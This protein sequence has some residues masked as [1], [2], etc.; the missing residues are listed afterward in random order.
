MI[1]QF[2]VG[3]SI[4]VGIHEFG[5]LIAAKGFGMRVEKFSIGFPPKIF[6]VKYGETEYSFGAVPLGGFVKI[7]GMIDES[8]DTKKMAQ[9]PEPYEF[10]AKPAWQ[11]LI[12]MLGGIIM[13]VLTGIIVFVSIT[14]FVGDNYI[15]I[16]EANK[17][18]I[19]AYE[20]GEKV[21]LQTGDRILTVNGEKV[22]RFKDL[23]SP[24]V[25]LGTDA[26]YT[27]DRNGQELRIDL[28]NDFIEDY[29][30][31]TAAGF[32]TV[33]RPF[34]IDEVQKDSPAEAAGL[35]PDDKILSINGMVTTYYAEFAAAREKFAGKEAVFL[36]ERNGQTMRKVIK[37]G[38]DNRVGFRP[39]S[40]LES[41]T[42]TYT[43]GESLGVGTAR[44]FSVV[45]N[46]IKAFG[47]I[48]AGEV[49]AQ[50]SI[51]GPIG[52]VKFFGG[53]W[54]WVHFWSLVGLLSMILAFM[55]LLP[56]PALDGGHVV[57]LLY[58]MV[59]GRKPS[60]KFLENAQKAGMLILLSI[61][62]FAIFNDVVNLF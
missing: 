52:I 42:T 48:F 49:S 34:A 37:I 1:G 26:Y 11:R 46:N 13:N 29:S 2:V 60:D 16:D 59:S 10:R 20:L 22:E 4:L 32:I 45:T 50:K 19:N 44:A 3:L 55:N 14:Y 31:A 56:I 17:H 23:T 8:L 57:F 5:H 39:K 33:R 6:G 24:D 58:E 38:N 21:G 27:I 28:P 47:K 30:E 41:S 7:T 51:S 40:L 54:D 12:V 25:I 61:M 15:S 43:F 62:A 53:T 18:G 35:Q 9:E 36:I